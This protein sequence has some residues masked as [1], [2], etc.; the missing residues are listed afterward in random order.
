MKQKWL[1][2]LNDDDDAHT[3]VMYVDARNAHDAVEIVRAARG[4]T[5]N[6]FAIAVS[7]EMFNNRE[8]EEVA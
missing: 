7:Q 3:Y 6:T 1:V 5:D 4:A 8:F 2:V